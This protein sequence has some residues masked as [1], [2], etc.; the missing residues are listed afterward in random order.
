MSDAEQETV[1]GQ[2][3]VT[4]RAATIQPPSIHVSPPP[5]LNKS[6]NLVEEWEI[7]K[8]M[9][10]NYAVIAQLDQQSKQ[11]QQATFLHTIG[12]KGIQLY[13]G[14][15]FDDAEDTHDVALIIQKLDTIIIG[16]INVIYERYIFNNRSQ[17]EESIDAYVADLRKLAK[18][19]QFCECLSSELIRDLIV[20]GVKEASTRKV[21]LQKRDLTLDM[22]IDICRGAE[23]TAAQLK[24]IRGEE[25]KVTES[26]SKI[27]ANSNRRWKNRTQSDR[28]TQA[29]ECQF[30]GKEHVPGRKECPAFGRKCSNCN[31]YNHFSIKCPNKSVKSKS[32]YQVTQTHDDSR[33]DLDC[34]AERIIMIEVEDSVNKINSGKDIFAKLSVHH[35]PVVFQV[36]SGAST[37]ILP[38]KFLQNEEIKPSKKT[39]KMWNGTIVK[40][41]GECFVHVKNQRNGRRYN[42]LFTIVEGESLKPILGKTASEKLGFIT[43]HYDQ[44]QQVN[45]VKPDSGQDFFER[46]P[47]VFD[48]T[49]VGSIPGEASLSIKESITPSELPPRR[50]PIAIRDKLKQEL[51]ELVKQG[52]IAP[53]THPTD[54]VSQMTV[55]LKKTGKWR[56]C[57]DPR[58]LNL[59]LK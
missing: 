7:F 31:R 11:Y 51:E 54:W 33:S 21:L 25:D 16:K 32:V 40:P 47:D 59:A 22:A 42:V 58:P 45:V 34:E 24:K 1:P 37:N 14:I 53:V 9:Y 52:V 23:A 43:V 19:C 29:S 35:T 26:V 17:G 8:T 56:I 46:F 18:T 13:N 28:K 15:H 6:G 20:I 50:E 2:V 38:K 49:T 12:I 39:L 27:K 44:F 3:P 36:D 30:C 5:G 48:E 4:L 10:R 41:L 55:Q 57:I